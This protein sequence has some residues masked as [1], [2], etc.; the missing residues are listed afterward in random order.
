MLPMD[1]SSLSN[2]T[3]VRTPDNNES[4]ASVAQNQN[5]PDSSVNDDASEAPKPTPA[6]LPPG[7]GT[8]VDQLV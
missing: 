8:R 2:T 4:R 6:P 1:I 3:P 7:Q 5:T